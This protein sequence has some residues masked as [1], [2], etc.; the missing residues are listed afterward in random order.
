MSCDLDSPPHPATEVLEIEC[1]LSKFAHD[2]KMSGASDMPE[3]W[4]AIQRDLD[5]HSITL[6]C[7]AGCNLL[8]QTG[9]K[10]LP[11]V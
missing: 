6:L 9:R 8:E 3:G 11:C 10:R 4:D 1:T 7:P 2:S 5:K